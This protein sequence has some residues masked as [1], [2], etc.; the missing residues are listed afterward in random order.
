MHDKNL[1]VGTDVYAKQQQS[2]SCLNAIFSQPEDCV[3]ETVATWC[4]FSSL[5]VEFWE[6]GDIRYFQVIESNCLWR[7]LIHSG[8]TVCDLVFHS[9]SVLQVC[10]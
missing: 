2:V 4:R 5:T 6:F 1:K 8:L 9:P 7:N 3:Q 10:S